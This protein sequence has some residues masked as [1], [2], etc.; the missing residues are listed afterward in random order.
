M[1]RAAPEVLS[2]FPLSYPPRALPLSLPCQP[3]RA[4]RRGHPRLHATLLSGAAAPVRGPNEFRQ[5]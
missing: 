1:G 5:A 4:A 3:F 2:L